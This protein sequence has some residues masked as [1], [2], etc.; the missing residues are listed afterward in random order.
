M[1]F[2]YAVKNPAKTI[3]TFQFNPALKDG[4]IYR[5]FYNH[6]PVCSRILGIMGV[7]C[8]K[9]S[10]TSES[11]STSMYFLFELCESSISS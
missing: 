10:K 1:I 2:G 5:C 9:N 3:S 11:V 8:Y 6:S 7:S 4:A